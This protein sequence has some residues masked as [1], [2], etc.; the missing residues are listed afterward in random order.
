M[1]EVFLVEGGG[2]SLV[3]RR[4]NRESTMSMNMRDFQLAIG[5]FIWLL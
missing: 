1:N 4:G 5:L 2:Y 3:K